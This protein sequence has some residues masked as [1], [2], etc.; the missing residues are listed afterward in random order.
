MSRIIGKDA[1]AVLVAGGQD[2][3]EVEA[4]Q[5]AVWELLK[6]FRL[7]GEKIGR[8]WG[9]CAFRALEALCPAAAECLREEGAHVADERFGEPDWEAP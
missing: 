9:G 4:R 8:G 2:S 3:P 6:G 5:R 7:Y 1:D